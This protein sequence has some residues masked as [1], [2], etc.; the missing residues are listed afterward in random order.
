MPVQRSTTEDD[1]TA[2]A[3]KRF[4][5]TPDPRL[6]QIML[7]LVKHLHAFVKEVEL[8][9]AEWFQ[10][11]EILTEAGRMCSDKR[12]E[13]I[14][15]SDTLGVSM[16]VDLINHRKPD[17]ATESTVFGPFH[18]LGA[19]ELSAGGNIAHRDKTGTPTLVSGRVLDLDGKPIAGALLDV[20]QT[21]SSGLYDSQDEGL[22]GELH[23]RG[24]F[25]TDP[26][27]RYLIRTVLPVNYPIPSDGPVGAMLRATGRHPWRPAHIHFVVSA[28]GYD[29]VTTH[30]F[31]RTDEYLGSDAVFAVKDSLICDFVRHEKAGDTAARLGIEPPYYTTEFDFRLKPAAEP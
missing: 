10:A 20:W 5:Q 23:M 21:Q 14:L 27:G 16:V 17:G 4:S 29:P 18:R 7:A 22:G 15:F 9:E 28:E 31:D 24:K 25:R 12:Q 19:P 1:I 8:T 11:I 3:L 30:I 26:E 2:E 13:F 6:Q